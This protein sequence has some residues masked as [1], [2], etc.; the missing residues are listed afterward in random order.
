MFQILHRLCFI[1]LTLLTLL[2]I[3]KLPEL[4]ITFDGV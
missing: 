3:L 1:S 2:L 4:R